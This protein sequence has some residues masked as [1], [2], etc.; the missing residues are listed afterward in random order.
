MS[1]R[2]C[3]VSIKAGLHVTS[4]FAFSFDLC[5]HILENANVKCKHNHL[6]LQNPL[7]M[8]DTNTNA[9]VTCKQGLRVC[10]H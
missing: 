3:S 4:A 8:F 1:M 10:S 2:Y 6:L 5:R 7:L 9:D